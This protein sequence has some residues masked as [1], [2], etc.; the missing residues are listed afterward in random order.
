MAVNKP[1]LT[2][3]PL[4]FGALAASRPPTGDREREHREGNMLAYDTR[5]LTAFTRI[6]WFSIFEYIIYSYISWLEQRR[7]TRAPAGRSG[8]KLS[9]KALA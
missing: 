5:D 6:D 9:D 1:H 4:S 3:S 7:V 8:R 2:A